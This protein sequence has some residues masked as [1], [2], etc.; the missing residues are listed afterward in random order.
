MSDPGMYRRPETVIT[1]GP[2][3]PLP[4]DTEGL[5]LNLIGAIEQTDWYHALPRE[6]E[7]QS[8]AATTLTI[9]LQACHHWRRHVIS[10]EVPVIRLI[11]SEG[12]DRGIHGQSKR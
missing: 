6:T 2:L 1:E 8:H 7:E 4:E 3:I 11:N 5:L 12:F 9:V 10:K